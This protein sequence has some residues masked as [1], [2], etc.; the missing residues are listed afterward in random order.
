LITLIK[1]EAHQVTKTTNETTKNRVAMNVC[2]QM[3]T[4]RNKYLHLK[5]RSFKEGFAKS[6]KEVNKKIWKLHKGL[7]QVRDA[8]VKS[9]TIQ[10]GSKNFS[11]TIAKN[12]RLICLR[13]L[14]EQNQGFAVL[15]IIKIFLRLHLPYYPDGIIQ[16]EFVGTFLPRIA[17]SWHTLLMEKNS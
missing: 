13:S 11:T 5:N 3:D 1:N 17:L 2:L 14:I 7:F 8:S 15:Y 10:L 16:V 9:Q 6:I 12:Q 4:I